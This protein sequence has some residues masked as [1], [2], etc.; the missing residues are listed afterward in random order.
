MK[1]HQIIL[2]RV[3]QIQRVR[4]RRIRRKRSEWDMITFI[5]NLIHQLKK[6]IFFITILYKCIKVRFISSKS[7]CFESFKNFKKV[8]IITCKKCSHL[9]ES[10]TFL[11]IQTKYC[12]FY[13]DNRQRHKPTRSKSHTIK[14]HSL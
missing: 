2:R 13:W 9:Q 11:L 6:I 12:Y 8:F 14:L 10:T 7:E 5:Q 3:L 1:G 4:S